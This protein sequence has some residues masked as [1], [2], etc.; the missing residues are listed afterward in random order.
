[1]N[2]IYRDAVES[3]KIDGDNFAESAMKGVYLGQKAAL[4]ELHRIV[5]KIYI[6]HAKDGFLSLTSQQKS[7]ITANT[8]KVLKDMGFKL[9][10]SEVEAV[11]AML[12]EVFKTTYYKNAFTMESGMSVNL[13]FNI[14]KKEFVD[15]AVN[16]KF[17]GEL[18][19]N[20]IWA[21]KAGLIDSIQSSLVDAYNGKKTIDKIGR[22]I[23]DTFNVQAYESQR[24]VRTENARIQSQA[25]EDIGRASGVEQVL[26]SSTLDSRT[27]EFCQE[28]DG[29]IF[30]IDDPDKPEIPVHPNCRSA[31]INVPYAGFSPTSRRDNETKEIIAYKNYAD[32]AKDKG[33]D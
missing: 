12:G 26:F 3:I 24:L 14:L 7:T 18:F 9:G 23:R 22:E 15:A 1:M 5:G 30:G 16:H 4:D 8:T 28:N 13:K 29:K 32:W 2:K 11:T 6:D 19:S 31:Y 17:K 21:N 27:S 20:R 33:V 10:T 25:S